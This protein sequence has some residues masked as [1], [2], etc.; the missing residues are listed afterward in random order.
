MLRCG[1]L[2]RCNYY[3]SSDGI[4]NGYVQSDASDI[5]SVHTYQLI[6]EGFLSVHMLPLIATSTRSGNSSSRTSMAF[7]QPLDTCVGRMSQRENESLRREKV[8][9]VWMEG[10]KQQRNRGLI[11]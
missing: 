7:K 1:K 5:I 10:S 6:A 4:D 3:T 8:K 9:K 2:W 11:H